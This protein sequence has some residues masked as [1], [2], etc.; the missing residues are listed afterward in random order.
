MKTFLIDLDGTMYRG[1]DTIPGAKEF[2]DTCIERKIPFY[3]LTNN[4]TRT[5]QENKE[6]M[7]KLGFKGIKESHFFTSSMAAAQTICKT[8]DKRK[9]YVVGQAGLKEA[10]IENGFEIVEDDADFVFVGLDAHAD[11]QL[12]SKALSQLMKGARLVGTNSD[13][14]LPDGDSFKIGNGSI[15]AMFEYASEQISPKIGKPYAPILNEALAT[16]GLT[17]EEV[18]IVG[19]NLETDIM[20]GVNC[21]VDTLFVTSGVHSFEDIERFNIHPTYR[22]HNLMEWFNF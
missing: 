7:E 1:N 15:V 21:G 3:F 22:V 19:D 14:K 11:Y 17:K 13:R 8:S 16:F 10:L 2:I 6:H 4:A 9:A 12:Y 5:R 20:L 18:I